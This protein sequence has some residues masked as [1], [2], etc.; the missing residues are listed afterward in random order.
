MFSGA[1]AK[2]MGAMVKR[3]AAMSF[4]ARVPR[5]PQQRNHVR[6]R[7]RFVSGMLPL[8]RKAWHASEPRDLPLQGIA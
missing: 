5:F 1:M 2:R 6:T 8:L 3:S 7:V 4:A